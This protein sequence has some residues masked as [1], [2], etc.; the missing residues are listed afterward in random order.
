ME[1]LYTYTIFFVL[2]GIIAVPYWIRVARHR[3]ESESKLVRSV[4]AGILT[5]VT[6]HP[7]IDIVQCIGCGSC[8]KV[9]PESVLGIVEGR[10]AIVSG[11]KCVGHALCE[12]VCPVGAITMGFGTPKEGQEIP[13]Y[14]EH[15]QTNVPG[16]YIVGELGGIGLI[17]NAV[18]HAT[19][20]LEHIARQGARGTQLDYDVV[21]I[22]AG[23]AGLTAGLA[24]KEH[25]LRYVVLEQGSIGGTILHYPRQKLILTSP[26]EL[27]LYGRLRISE[28]PKEELLEIWTGIVKK[29][30]LNIVENA[31]AE[32]LEKA[33][34]GFIVKHGASSYTTKNIV[35]A[36][37]R[38][39]SPRKLGVP[40]EYLPKVA[41]QLIDAEA[42]NGINILVVGGGD[43]A[44]EA[45][46]ALARQKGNTVTISYRREEFVR[47]KEKNEKHLQDM[48]HAK[49]I[50]VVFNSN[51]AEIRADT[52]VVHENTGRRHTLPNDYVFV[53]AGGE[54]PSEMLKRAGVR[55]RTK[56]SDSTTTR[57]TRAA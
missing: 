52:V 30:S 57:P 2:L 31:K 12:D 24:A 15:Y 35:L 23:P 44:I 19:E 50:I 38:R 46:V 1:S 43:S 20:A 33:S 9:C 25:G 55:L 48:I 47:L 34:E 16:L 56:E 41:Y 21:I 28:I 11:M 49:K 37:G 8:V 26:V 14:D 3:R 22:G 10:A 32:S 53:F 17:K 51:I 42:Y 27:P 7:H 39:G 45:A 18:V 36:L 5:P 6:L 54:L 40:G 29:Y 4:H 13:W